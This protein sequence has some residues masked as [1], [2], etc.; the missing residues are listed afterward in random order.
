MQ[1]E[2]LGKILDLLKERGELGASSVCE[3]LADLSLVTVR[4]YLVHLTKLQFLEQ[5]GKGRSLK[6]KLSKKGIVLRDYPWYDYKNLNEEF[7]KAKTEFDFEVFDLLNIE[8]FSSEEI[9]KL[10]IATKQFNQKKIDGS[11]TIHK[12]ELER[13]VIELSWKSSRIEGN[14]YTLLDTEMLLKEGLKSKR[15]TESET[16]MVLNHKITFDYILK[17]KDSFKEL[18][19]EKIEKIHSPLSF[20]LGIQNGFRN[21]NVGITGTL[22]RPLPNKEL[23][24]KAFENLVKLIN[25][26]ENSYAKALTSILLLSYIQG[27]EDGNKRTSRLVGNAILLANNL[28]PL[29]YRT[30]EEDEYKTATLIF[31]EQNSVE[32]FK[33]IFIE[34]YIFSCNTYNLG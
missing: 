25:N 24:E 16:R 1:K 8:I 18:S 7:R 6:Y 28:A 22:Y 12:K 9:E 19:V 27:F 29:S 21:F 5:V 17:N 33:K 3:Y 32:A 15:N 34:Q 11:E 23:I 13:F 30:T 2:V 10:D 4:R 20:D 31:Y 14:T 26:T